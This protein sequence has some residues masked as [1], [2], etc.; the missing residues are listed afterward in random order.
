M[1]WWD[2]AKSFI[3]T[4][5][6]TASKEPI[7]GEETT[8]EPVKFDKEKVKA[9]VCEH[10][11]VMAIP[12][13]IASVICGTYLVLNNRPSSWLQYG[14][15]H[16]LTVGGAGLIGFGLNWDYE[17]K[18]KKNTQPNSSNIGEKV[19]DIPAMA[20]EEPQAVQ[21]SGTASASVQEESSAVIE[22]EVSV[23]KF[24]NNILN[25][26]EKKQLWANNKDRIDAFVSSLM[27]AIKSAKNSKIAIPDKGLNFKAADYADIF[28]TDLLEKI[29]TLYKKLSELHTRYFTEYRSKLSSSDYTAI[30][31]LAP[32]WNDEEIKLVQDQVNRI[33]DV[34]GRSSI[35]IKLIQ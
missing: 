5:G 14:A 3:P 19:V 34:L 6:W 10:P 35:D 1:S 7:S 22:K 30:N 27:N 25:S 33:T 4:K 32:Q 15:G 28:T 20:P 2:T 8:E 31:I 26:F 21:K 23:K 11:Q 17:N 12:L 24:G 9:F 16:V 29:G 13:G 18:I